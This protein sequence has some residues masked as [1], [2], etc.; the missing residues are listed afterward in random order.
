MSATEPDRHGAV[1]WTGVVVGWL[2]IAWGLWLVAARPPETRPINFAAFFVGL[3]L[4]HDLVLAPV[5]MSAGAALRRRAPALAAGAVAAGLVV[6]S[7]VVVYAIPLWLDRATKT[8]QN[9]SFL[10]RD[11]VVG[12]VIVLTLTWI[13]VGAVVLGRVLGSRPR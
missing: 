12:V 13:V 5:V 10:S 2:V 8:A 6:S 1:F 7:I 4:V 9:P 3:A 11:P